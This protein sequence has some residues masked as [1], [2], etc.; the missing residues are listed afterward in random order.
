MDPKKGVSNPLFPKKRGLSPNGIHWLALL[1]PN[2]G[3]INGTFPQHP[4]SQPDLKTYCDLRVNPL[5]KLNESVPK[6]MVLPLYGMN[7]RSGS[8]RSSRRY[9]VFCGDHFTR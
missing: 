1:G 2:P 9:S 8:S 4:L 6:R 5:T 3:V 7:I